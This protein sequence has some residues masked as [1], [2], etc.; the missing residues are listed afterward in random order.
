M[1]PEIDDVYWMNDL[2][3]RETNFSYP[4]E[5]Q[6]KIIL[7]LDKHY[8][9]YV[10]QTNVR[11]YDFKTEGEIINAKDYCGEEYLESINWSTPIKCLIEKDD[12]YDFCFRDI[13]TGKIIFGIFK[14]MIKSYDNGY[15]DIDVI[16]D[17]Y[18]EAYESNSDDNSDSD[19]LKNL[20]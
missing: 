12:A 19:F 16:Y 13:E 2:V 14:K 6:N 5:K 8:I 3:G 4:L 20:V 1:L 15:E 18:C 10:E 11:R 17:V 7:R 9:I